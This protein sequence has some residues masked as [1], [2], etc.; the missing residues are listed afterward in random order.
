MYYTQGKKN[1]SIREVDVDS[2]KSD[3]VDKKGDSMI[4]FKLKTTY[5]DPK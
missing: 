4:L 1:E 5:L 3:L 2:I